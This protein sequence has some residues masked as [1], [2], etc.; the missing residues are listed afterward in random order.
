MGR[1]T[2]YKCETCGAGPGV[3]LFRSYSS[4]Y[5][6]LCCRRCAIES[7]TKSGALASVEPGETEIGWLVC[8]VP[9]TR[10]GPEGE[11]D[12]NT[13]WWGYTS[14]P[15][16][17]LTWWRSLA[18]EPCAKCMISTQRAADELRGLREYIRERGPTFGQLNTYVETRLSQLAVAAPQPDIL[19]DLSAEDLQW[20]ADA[21]DSRID[22]TEGTGRYFMFHERFEQA[23][24]E[25]GK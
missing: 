21:I 20:I 9:D 22:T 13:G 12:S 18:L 3:R 16:K 5:V 4:S 1:V 17:D 11:I 6:E 19:A 7:Q 10:P 23:A 8:A 15:S 2:A 25:R 14:I 24:K